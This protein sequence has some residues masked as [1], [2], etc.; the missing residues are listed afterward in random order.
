[1]AT[2]RIDRVTK[3]ASG[4][5]LRV[6]SGANWYGAFL[7]SGL[8]HLVGQT[9]DADIKTSEKYGATIAKYKKT[10]P[11]PAIQAPVSKQ[12]LPSGVAPYWMPFA[13]NVCAHAIAAG[14]VK[15]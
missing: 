10:E 8:E 14:I 4:K 13:S 5:G 3:T 6:L 11:D 9:I 7:D 15:E 2:I 1:M 12:P